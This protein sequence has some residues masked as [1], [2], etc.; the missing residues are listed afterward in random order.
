MPTDANTPRIA[1]TTKSSIKVKPGVRK[2]NFLFSL[3]TIIAITQ[4]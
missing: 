3:N 4:H 2:N 1:T